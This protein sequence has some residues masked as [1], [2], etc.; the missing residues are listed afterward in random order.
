MIR[1]YIY[2]LLFFALFLVACDSNPPQNRSTATDQLDASS[3]YVD[4]QRFLWQRPEIVLDLLG[5]LT[6]KTIA[7]IGAGYGFFTFRL[8]E[9]CS[10][11]IAIDISEEVEDYLK[12]NTPPEL[13]E[14]VEVRLVSPSSPSLAAAE[15]DVAVMVNTYMY[16]DHRVD[17]LKKVHRGLSENGKILINDFKKKQT[18]VG[19][20]YP[21]RVP[22]YGVEEELKRAGFRVLRTD[23]TSLEYQYIV[24]AEKAE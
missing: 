10:K 13:K 15:I 1:R 16:L 11:V 8:A 12:R 21:S 14:K 3:N 18:S 17:Y 20:P 23:D 6:D 5:D 24:V 22:L 7:D 19:P 2:L 4:T 9:Q